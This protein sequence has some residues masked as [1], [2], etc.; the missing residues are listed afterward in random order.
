MPEQEGWGMILPL[1]EPLW[2]PLVESPGFSRNNT[3]G[4]A[5]PSRRLTV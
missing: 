4:G 1:R 2:E 5:P 3:G